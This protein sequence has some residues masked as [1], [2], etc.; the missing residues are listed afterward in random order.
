[1]SDPIKVVDMDEKFMD[2][3]Y[4]R[5]NL[6]DGKFS[7][8]AARADPV[9]FAK[10]MIGFT[11]RDYQAK[12]FDMVTENQKVALVKGRQI[13]FS[14]TIA[15][16]CLWYGWFKKA[17]TGGLQNTK[18]CVVSKDDDAAK[19]LLQLIKDFMYMGDKHMSNFLKGTKLHNTNIFSNDIVVSNVDKLKL[20]NGTEICSFPPTA[21]VRGGSF[22]IIFVDE[23]AFLNNPSIDKFFWTDAMPTIS[24]TA[25]KVIVSSTPNGYGDEFY[26]IIDPEGKKDKH[27]F[28]RASF[29]Y[30]IN[31]SEVYQQQIDVLMSHMEEAKFK[32]EYLCDFTENE[33]SF[34]SSKRVLEM[35]DDTVRDMELDKHVYVCGIDY[36]MTQARTVITLVT[37]IEGFIYRAYFK[38]F[39]SGWD[40][41]GVIPFMEGLR[42]RFNISKIVVDDCAQGDSVNKKMIEMGWN[43]DLFDF[44]KSKIEA[45]CAFR[46]KINKVPVCE[47]KMA[48]DKRTEQQFLAMKQEE[49]PQGYLKIHKPK[50]GNDDI[51]DSMIMACWH[52]LKT[53]T[54]GV[55]SFLA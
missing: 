49:T 26:N 2:E 53:G 19:K 31:G 48:P 27:D 22:D 52:Y 44:K 12:M 42:D 50:R 7:T 43:V 21:K 13:G 39:P 51:V 47:V 35:F 55:R 23:F 38:E 30:T 6:K 17:K 5:L 25:G 36:G 37:Q 33:V 16:Y 28:V 14:T 10:H 45:F 32:Q 40:I 34:F 15:L 46:N 54:R 18:I 4:D 9:Y 29:P 11:V 8:K 1:M 24:E 41:N 3:Y 20:K